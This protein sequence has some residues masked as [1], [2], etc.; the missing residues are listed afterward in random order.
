MENYAKIEDGNRIIAVD[1]SD[2]ETVS[3][4]LTEWD[5]HLANIGVM[6]SP[7]ERNSNDYGDKDIATG[8]QN[9]EEDYDRIALEVDDATTD[10]QSA[11][12]RL[13]MCLS[14]CGWDYLDKEV[15]EEMTE[16][17]DRAETLASA[18]D[19]LSTHIRNRPDVKAIE[20]CPYVDIIR[21]FRIWVDVE[22]Y[23][24]TTGENYDNDRILEIVRY[25]NIAYRGGVFTVTV[26]NEDGKEI[27]SVSGVTFSSELPTDD[28]IIEYVR[29]GM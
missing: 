2:W 11:N 20:Y 6:I 29:T 15:I 23:E 24:K 21:Y 28:E 5:E 1:Y 18:V 25:F 3:D 4:I 16:I 8:I 12:A 13:E 10:Y 26:E 22:T 17:E 27:D 14:E 7:Y 9:W 19:E